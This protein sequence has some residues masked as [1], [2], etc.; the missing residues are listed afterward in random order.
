M[1]THWTNEL[2]YNGCISIKKLNETG[3]AFRFNN[4]TGFYIDFNKSFSISPELKTF[5]NLNIKTSI[6]A[7]LGPALPKLVQ[8]FNCFTCC[9]PPLSTPIPVYWLK[10]F[11]SQ[12]N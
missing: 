11:L 4:K 3:K 7:E 2:S 1:K 12:G 5:L 10:A 9:H 8:L 6:E